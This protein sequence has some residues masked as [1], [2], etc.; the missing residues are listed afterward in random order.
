MSALDKTFRQDFGRAG[1]RGAGPTSSCPDPFVTAT[2]VDPFG[3]P[4]GVMYNP[5]YL[6]ILTSFKP[7]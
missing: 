2:L 5:Y 6:E 7:A 4:L 1:T 3:N